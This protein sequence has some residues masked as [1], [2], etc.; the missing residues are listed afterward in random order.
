MQFA[1][2]HECVP[3]ERPIS[4]TQLLTNKY[5]SS[6]FWCNSTCSH[7][8]LE[9]THTFNHAVNIYLPYKVEIKQGQGCGIFVV[10]FL[11]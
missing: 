7:L 10:L 5:S 1:E 3:A 9:L 8:L 6:W 2:K 11:E 4:L